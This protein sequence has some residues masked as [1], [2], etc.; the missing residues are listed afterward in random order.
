MSDGYSS[1]PGKP[2]SLWLD[3]TP[4]TDLPA[5]Q[6]GI[7]TDVAV[8]GGGLAGL[9]AATLLKEAGKTVAVIE[10]RRIVHGVTGYT[11]AKLTSLHGLIYDHLVRHFGEEKARRY[12]E[13]NQAAIELVADTVRQK[14]IGC[15]FSRTE[16]YTCAESPDRVKEIEAEVEAARRLGL[17]ASLTDRTPLPFPVAA[18]VRF[19]NQARFH[20]RKYL[21]ALAAR[22]PGEGSSL[23]EQTRVTDISEGEP[24]TVV[25]DRGEIT[26]R[27]VIIAT[28]FPAVD[29]A[30]YFARLAPHRSYVLAVSLD[31]P[32]PPGMYLCE[33]PFYSLRSHPGPNGE[34]LL[35]GGE[36]HKAGQGGDTMARYH[37]V[38]QWA[39]GRFP[40]RSVEYR[41]STQDNWT[42]DRIPY[43]G[44]AAPGSRHLYVATGF[45]GWGMTGSTVAGMLLR[46]LILERENPWAELY[47]PN[48]FNLESV[49]PLVRENIDVAGH[50]F[51]D[52]LAHGAPAELA[53]GE[54][55][56]VETEQGKVATYQA[57]DGTLHRL[58][59]MCTHLGCVVSWNPGE[60]SWDCPC[61]GSR[62]AADGTVIH[63]PAIKDLE[64]M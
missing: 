24:C 43:V 22:I 21:L 36:K 18:A 25:T 35:V 56:L 28:H 4:E 62:F 12:G 15:D 46:D 2:T 23:F 33:E 34:L 45:G 13:A 1:L 44:R 63:G 20:P 51:G 9:T 42:P 47:D 32:V 61:H 41:W 40:V 64:K 59:P 16:A 5:L 14:G 19:D 8:I 53:P 11:T 37:R 60:K 10:A 3:T 38:E 26:A 58:S 57:E 39:R 29:K 54:G 31:G 17:P 6:S 50:F 48:R 49:P 52:R 30:L 55:A 27:D 7:T